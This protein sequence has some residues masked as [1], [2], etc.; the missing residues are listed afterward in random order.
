MGGRSGGQSVSLSEKPHRVL[1]AHTL[2]TAR[3]DM[4]VVNPRGGPS[5]VM[6][7]PLYFRRKELDGRVDANR[8]V[9]SG[10]IGELNQMLRLR[11]LFGTGLWK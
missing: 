3:T 6:N 5:F 1:D 8:L 11:R 10:I 9:R 4:V 7:A 2:L